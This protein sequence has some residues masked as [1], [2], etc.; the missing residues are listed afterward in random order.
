MEAN[1]R[2][3]LRKC[4]VPQHYRG[5]EHLVT[6]LMLAYKDPSYLR[7]LTYR[8]YPDVAKAHGTKA[9]CVKRAIRQAVETAFTNMDYDFA[10]ELFGYTVSFSRG[11][12]TNKHFIAALLEA[13]KT[14]ETD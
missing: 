3:L 11:K 13:L 4:G 2:K 6:A 5:Y 7:E 1:V 9:A 10:Y 12:P 14:Y 8:L